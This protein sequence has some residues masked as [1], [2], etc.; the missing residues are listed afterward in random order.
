MRVGLIG[1]GRIG[2]LHARTLAGSPAVSELVIADADPAR[3]VALAATVGAGTAAV[4]E[5]FTGRAD[6]LVIAAPTAAHAGLVERALDRGLATFCEKPLAADVPATRALVERAAGGAAVLQVGFQRRFDPGHRAVRDA[7]AGGRL[8]W[9]HSVLAVTYDASPP[10]ADY[11]ATSG[12]I[13]RDCH[14]HDFDAVRFVTGREVVRVFATGGNRGPGFFAACGDVAA[15]AATL[16]LD[17]GTVAA[18]LGGRYNGAGYDVR[19]EVHGSA[20]MMAAGLDDRAALDSAEPGSR[21]TAGDAAPTPRYVSFVD[22]F[23]A[24]Y[25][26]EIA[27]FLDCAAGRTANPCPPADALEAL[28]VAEAASRSLAERRPVDLA[29]VRAGAEARR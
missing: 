16:E 1:A 20:G 5:L 24:A 22:R 25:A 15:S 4:A 23:A 7:V 26:A 29:E 3:A 10:P 11:I 19:L 18:L 13:F 12:G 28:Y 6:I 14:I 9:L 27:A 2:A 17:D 8:G 21:P